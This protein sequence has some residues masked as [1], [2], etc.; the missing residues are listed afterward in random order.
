MRD[1]W[2]EGGIG[3]KELLC[4][5]VTGWKPMLLCPADERVFRLRAS[6]CPVLEIACN[7]GSERVWIPLKRESSR[8]RSLQVCYLDAHRSIGF[9]PVKRRPR[10]GF[11]D[12]GLH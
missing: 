10:P 11:L 2:F 8:R 4:G 6:L 7:L 5:W 1:C 12:I 3:W 9:Q